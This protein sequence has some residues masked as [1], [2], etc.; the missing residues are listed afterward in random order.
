MK[1]N[2]ILLVALALL[3]SVTLLA[4]CGSNESLTPKEKLDKAVNNMM[5]MKS[6]EQSGEI[7]FNFDIP[8]SDPMT[9]AYLQMFNNAKIN[10]N[11]K[12]DMEN[13]KSK[14]EMAV[15]LGGMSYTMEM[16]STAEK[17]VMKIPMI[18]QYLYMDM[19]EETLGV[20]KEEQEEFT[21]ISRDMAKS[22]LGSVKED[23]IKENG[24][25]EIEIEGKKVDTTHLAIDVT[26]EEAK[27]LI[28]D[29]VISMIEDENMRKYF[30][31]SMKTTSN[32]QGAELSEEE[33]NS[34]FDEMKKQVEEGFKEL[35]NE[36]N[37]DK[38]AINYFI[39]SDNNLRK[40]DFEIAVTGKDQETGE[41]ISVALNGKINVWNIN[42]DI[43]VELPELTEENS[44][45][46]ME[47]QN[48]MMMPIQ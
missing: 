24:D 6:A 10:I 9:G 35:E 13:K 25:K 40:L 1:K 34:Q 14:A 45:N 4:G 48:Q 29:I 5:D 16:F 2:K 47:M 7:G 28:K 8:S 36:I 18:P 22:L 43:T 27:G 17:I 32:M 26:N 31:K 42:G 38:I 30:V 41:D 20:T 46:M 39:D 44:M 15:N 3:L 23:Y 33:I 11:A 12:T 21:N 19:N 37:F